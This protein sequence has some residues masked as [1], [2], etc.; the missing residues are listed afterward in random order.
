MK[1]FPNIP[2]EYIICF[3]LFGMI[4]LKMMKIDSWTDLA[5]GSILG[6]LFGVKAEQIR[7][8]RKLK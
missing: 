8:E 6:W 7:I 4:V 3:L 1:K 2:R 5:L